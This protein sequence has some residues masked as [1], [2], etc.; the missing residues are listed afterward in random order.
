MNSYVVLWLNKDGWN[1]KQ[2]PDAVSADAYAH[3]VRGAMKNG[4]TPT[5]K[6]IVAS[7]DRVVELL[8]A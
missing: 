4:S 6:V 2:Y 3:F 7:L 8:T 1:I 5:T